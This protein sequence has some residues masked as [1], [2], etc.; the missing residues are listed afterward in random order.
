VFHKIPKSKSSKI[1][2]NVSAA[3]WSR[4]QKKHSNPIFKENIQ[5]RKKKN[6]FNMASPS[7]QEC[8]T[9]FFLFPSIAKK[10]LQNVPKLF[11]K[12]FTVVFLFFPKRKKKQKKR[13]KNVSQKIYCC[14]HHNNMK[15]CSKYYK[16]LIN[17][18]LPRPN[19]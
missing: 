3:P 9:T 10:I 12:W 16:L 7:H 13:P 1:N 15:K 2:L 8:Q 14:F 5:K 6:H 19:K 18:K 17:Y 11:L 4:C